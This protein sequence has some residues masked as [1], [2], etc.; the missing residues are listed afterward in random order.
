MKKRSSKKV[1]RSGKK[2]KKKKEKDLTPD[3]SEE[4]L[5]QELVS[6]GIIKR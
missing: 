4:S 5:F 1:K 6:N 3:R 2:S